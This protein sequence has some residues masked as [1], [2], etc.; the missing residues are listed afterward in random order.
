M[1][2]SYPFLKISQKYNREYSHILLAASLMYRGIIPTFIR[3]GS[4]LE[5]D[6]LSVCAQHRCIQNGTRAYEDR[7]DLLT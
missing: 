1:K 6:L 4:P 5:L 7:Y 3:S 2:T